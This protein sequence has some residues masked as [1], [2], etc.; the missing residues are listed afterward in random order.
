MG[1]GGDAQ[2]LGVEQP[3]DH[4]ILRDRLVTGRKT[5]SSSGKLDYGSRLSQKAE[6]IMSCGSSTW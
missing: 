3:R 4:V 1:R 2:A 6:R 5:L